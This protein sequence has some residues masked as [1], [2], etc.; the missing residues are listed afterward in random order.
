MKGR[1]E[2]FYGSEEQFDLQ[3]LKPILDLESSREVEAVE[4]GWAINE[5]KWYNSR[6]T[7]IHLENYKKPKKISGYKFTYYKT[8]T[9]KQLNEVDIVYQAFLDYK[10]FKRIYNLTPNDPKTSWLLCESDKIHAFTMFTE[11]DGALESNLTAWDYSEL[12]KSI[13]KYIIGY[14]VEIALE[15]GLQHLYIGP[16]YGASAIYKAFLKGFQW[17]TG[18]EWSGDVERYVMLCQRDD[19]VLTLKDL[20]NLYASL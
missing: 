18:M 16:G 5:G 10:G 9:T 12:K 8:L 15:R 14:E 13:G 20:S 7:R 2:H 1:Y 4:Q 6:S 11:Y 19:T 3:L 17:W